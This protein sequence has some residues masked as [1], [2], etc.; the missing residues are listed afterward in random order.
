MARQI[1][2]L[3]VQ[4]HADWCVVVSA[5]E[6]DAQ[7]QVM[8]HRDP[9][10]RLLVERYRERHPGGLALGGGPARVLRTGNAEL[11]AEVDVATI[12]ALVY[13]PEAAQLI[14][15]L[16]MRSYPCV[17]LSARGRILGA[18]T[19]V[20]A[21][22]GRPYSIEDLKF[23]EDVGRR[24]AL[25]IDA[26]HSHR[27]IGL[28]EEV[29]ATVSHDLKSP[30]GAVVS[31][32]E[33]IAHKAPVGESGEF[34]RK[35]AALIQRSALR[36]DRLIS[37]LLDLAKIEAGSFRVEPLKAARS[38]AIGI[39][40]SRC[41]RTSLETRSNSRPKKIAWSSAWSSAGTRYCF[42]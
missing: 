31:S 19:F 25:T 24:A 26:V 33:L 2:E 5:R 34:F 35:Q 23:A 7:R 13:D 36:M 32:A 10:K 8:T 17:P 28:R 29:M 37:D 1:S 3:V 38:T 4:A 9:A 30:L 39:A 20:S 14:E 42:R 16:G 41:S 27:L 12:D 21:D 22:P 11:V 6:N 40:C 18:V 15:A